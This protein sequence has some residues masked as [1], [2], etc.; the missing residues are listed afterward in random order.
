[1]W[2]CPMHG[3]R[4]GVGLAFCEA[5]E[6]FSITVVTNCKTRSVW[7][8]QL[9][10]FGGKCEGK[11]ISMDLVVSQGW[12]NILTAGSA[13]SESLAF[14]F[15]WDEMQKNV[16]IKNNSKKKVPQQSLT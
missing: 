3:A 5:R 4:A 8:Y 12:V 14:G 15:Y 13:M 16:F 6:H 10:W 9:W 2:A 11:K 7:A 1:M